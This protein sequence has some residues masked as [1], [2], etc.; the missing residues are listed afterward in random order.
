MIEVRDVARLG[1]ACVTRVFLRT[2]GWYLFGDT[3]RRLF[4]RE[5]SVMDDFTSAGR[6]RILRVWI[7]WLSGRRRELSGKSRW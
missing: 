7:P 4:E 3:K 1:Y 2:S 6:G 5:I